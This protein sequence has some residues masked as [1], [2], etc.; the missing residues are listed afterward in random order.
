MFLLTVGNAKLSINDNEKTTTVTFHEHSTPDVTLEGVFQGANLQYFKSISS[1]IL[2]VFSLSEER[3]LN[4][5]CWLPDEETK[6]VH[7]RQF[8]VLLADVDINESGMFQV[9]ID[10]SEKN[11]RVFRED[12]NGE[13]THGI[14]TIS[15]VD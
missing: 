5:A 9:A 7:Y 15:L 10:D 2:S 4:I 6:K 12:K 13:L 3:M 1:V 14:S 8:Q 11:L